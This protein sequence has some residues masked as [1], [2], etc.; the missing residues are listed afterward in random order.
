MTIEN[1]QPS[2]SCSKSSVND[3]AVVGVKGTKRVAVRED[4][5]KKVGVGGE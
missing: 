5:T 3:R 2:K 4:E 1:L